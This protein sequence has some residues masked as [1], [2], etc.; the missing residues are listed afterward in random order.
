MKDGVNSWVISRGDGLSWKYS[1][2]Y[3][4]EPT[5]LYQVEMSLGLRLK[6]WRKRIKNSF[7]VVFREDEPKG[8]TYHEADRTAYTL[9]V[10]EESKA[11]GLALKEEFRKQMSVKRIFILIVL[12]IVI[13]V[14]YMI[15]TRQMTVGQGVPMG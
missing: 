2:R 14:V 8:I 11:L 1:D 6:H 7:I 4:I 3:Q 13:G 5:C 12:A 9:K 15:V 10:V